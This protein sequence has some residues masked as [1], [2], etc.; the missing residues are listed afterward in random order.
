MSGS[1]SPDSDEV[2]P[3]QEDRAILS[4]T[5]DCAEWAKP[6]PPAAADGDSGESGAD[7]GG[8]DSCRS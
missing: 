1:A 4:L 7:P 3:S 5:T 6:T 8:S 2:S